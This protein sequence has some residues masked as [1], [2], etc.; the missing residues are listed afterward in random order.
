MKSFEQHLSDIYEDQSSPRIDLSDQVPAREKVWDW[1][2]EEGPNQYIAPTNELP[3]TLELADDSTGTQTNICSELIFPT[4]A[5]Q[6][7]LNAMRQELTLMTHE[8]HILIAIREEITRALPPIPEI[9]IKKPIGLVKVLYLIRW[10]PTTFIS[11]QQYPGNPQIALERAITLTG[12][13]THAQA[14]PCLQYMRQTWPMSGER[15]L[16]VIQGLL[17]SKQDVRTQGLLLSS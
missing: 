9:S 1:F 5:Y 2:D 7:L 16:R 12:T 4:A 3:D 15:T 14:L 17:E 6:W 11:E 8:D 13:L 10:N